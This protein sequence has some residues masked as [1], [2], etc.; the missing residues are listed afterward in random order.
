MVV[1]VSSGVSKSI[2]AESDGFLL[3]VCKS[4]WDVMTIMKLLGLGE[5]LKGIFVLCMSFEGKG[6]ELFLMNG[7]VFV[8]MTPY[9]R[10]SETPRNFLAKNLSRG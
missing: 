2:G 1:S 6:S 9:I 8:T 5:W 4:L 10:T 3:L 7:I